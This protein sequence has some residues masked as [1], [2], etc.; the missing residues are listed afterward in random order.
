MYISG[1]FAL[2]IFLFLFISS[3]FKKP[4]P[5]YFPFFLLKKKFF[6]YTV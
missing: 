3:L 5:F 2:H 6:E 4:I 1:A